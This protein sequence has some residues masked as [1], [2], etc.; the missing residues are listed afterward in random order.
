MAI[1]MPTPRICP[2]RR[3]GTHRSADSLERLARKRLWLLAQEPLWLLAQ[4]ITAQRSSLAH[5]LVSATC[6]DRADGLRLRCWAQS[7]LRVLR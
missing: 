3:P 2:A 1:L 7:E 6:P 5:E 4:L